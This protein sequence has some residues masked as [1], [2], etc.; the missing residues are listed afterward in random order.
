MIGLRRR[1][2]IERWSGRPWAHG[3]RFNTKASWI[4]GRSSTHEAW[5]RLEK[6]SIQRTWRDPVPDR[7]LSCLQFAVRVPVTLPGIS[8]IPGDA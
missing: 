8:Q 5:D 1:Y 2:T 3:L 7:S 6:V 4:Q